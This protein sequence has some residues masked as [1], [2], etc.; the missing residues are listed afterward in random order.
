MQTP[1]KGTLFPIAVVLVGVLGVGLAQGRIPQDGG[2]TAAR[3]EL[4][5]LRRLLYLQEQ[6][7]DLVQQQ[8]QLTKRRI[9]ALTEGEKEPARIEIEVRVVEVVTQDSH[10]TTGPPEPGQA[11]P[12]KPVNGDWTNLDA[13]IAKLTEGLKA[14]PVP[15]CEIESILGLAALG[16]GV[17][18]AIPGQRYEALLAEVTAL[19]GASEVWRPRVTVGDGAQGEL[20]N[21]TLVPSIDADGELTFEPVGFAFSVL[22]K[23]RPGGA[24]DLALGIE[25][26]TQ[27][28]ETFIQRADG[29]SAAVPTV[30]KRALKTTVRLERGQTALIIMAPPTITTEGETTYL[31]YFVSPR[32]PPAR[33]AGDH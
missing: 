1:V 10:G 31:L 28:S 25:R 20:T 29:T 15:S 2:E 3:D 5:D 27:I 12:F 26:S 33:E 24:I 17:T 22:P 21:T 9:Q 19:E 32:I 8:I 16:G 14:R 11:R 6:Q 23:I 18:D 13:E 4:Q 7:L 30:S